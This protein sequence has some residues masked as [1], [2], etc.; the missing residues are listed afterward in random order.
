MRALLLLSGAVSTT[1]A[2]I[3]F[4]FLWAHRRYPGFAHWTVGTAMIAA[5][6]LLT[7]LRGIIPIVPS[8]IMSNLL[9]LTAPPVF[10]D[11]MRRYLGL[12][13]MTRTWYGASGA[14]L[15]PCL[16]FL[17][18]SDQIAIRTVILMVAGASFFAAI[19]VLLARQEGTGRSLLYSVLA[20]EFALMVATM[21]ARAAW[22]TLN[23]EF[24]VFADSP[25]QYLFFGATTVL[26]LG[27]TVTFILKTTARTASEL[28]GAQTELA[29]RVELLQRA[30]G[31]VKTLSGLLPIC[32]GC[33]RI[34]DDSGSWIQMEVY[35]R[36]RSNAEFTHGLCPDCLPKYFPR[37][38]PKA[39]P[40]SSA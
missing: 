12:E 20:V 27:I 3:M 30:L 11:G 2:V 10:L 39:E 34:R 8:V 40:P 21:L 7:G 1:L 37:A 19:V 29:A 9:I 15:V 32:S 14:A 16:Y 31:E 4:L 13:R 28:E 25:G 18:V 23:P 38:R 35:V 24:T 33:K 22:V 5:N 26:H 17:L 6:F 36:D